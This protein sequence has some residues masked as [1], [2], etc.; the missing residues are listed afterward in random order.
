MYVIDSSALA[1]Y[2][3]REPGWEE[4]SKR[5][6]EG[7]LTLELAL[8]ETANSLWKR[9]IRKDLS[10]DLATSVLNTLLEARPFKLEEQQELYPAAFKLAVEKKTTI[11]DALFIALALERKLPLATSDE[12]Q[13]SVAR[14]LGIRTIQIG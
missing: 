3:N 13:A 10:D 4:V 11:Y 2:V 7:C 8:K 5:L 9:V 1:K 14:S 12:Q 6:S